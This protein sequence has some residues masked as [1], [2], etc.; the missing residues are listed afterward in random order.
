MG[1]SNTTGSEAANPKP[2]GEAEQRDGDENVRPSPRKPFQ[3][4]GHASMLMGPLRAFKIQDG[5]YRTF[6]ASVDTFNVVPVCA[7]G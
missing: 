6:V 3:K 2:V 5:E 1:A 7:G 4:D